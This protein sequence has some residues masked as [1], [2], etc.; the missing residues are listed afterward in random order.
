MLRFGGVKAVAVAIALLACAGCED[1]KSAATLAQNHVSIPMRTYSMTLPNGMHLVID[2][3]H[4]S[5]VISVNLS[6]RVGSKDDPPGRAG[7]A[8]LFEHLMFQGSKHV[9]KGEYEM[10]L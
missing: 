7:F 10:Y 6:Y 9:A 3:D 4:R 1:A 8:H 5:P 2:E